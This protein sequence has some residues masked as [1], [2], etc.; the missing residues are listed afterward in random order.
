MDLDVEPEVVAN[1]EADV[2]FE[3]RIGA[4]DEDVVAIVQVADDERETMDVPT[5][6]V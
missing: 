2:I 4:E 6:E 3:E 1:V 5:T